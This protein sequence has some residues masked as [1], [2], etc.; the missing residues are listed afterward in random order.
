MGK[1][2]CRPVQIVAADAVIAARWLRS[3]AIKTAYNAPSTILAGNLICEDVARLERLAGELNRKA[4]RRRSGAGF[5]ALIDVGHAAAFARAVGRCRPAWPLNHHPAILR[6]A[7]AMRN[8]GRRKRRG[9]IS[10]DD[11]EMQA[12]VSG[13]FSCEER[14]AKRLAA[15]LRRSATWDR[16]LGEVRARG[17]TIL[18]TDL[19][20]Y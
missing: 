12:R 14:H 2:D 1:R 16:W 9:R 4:L 3:V 8:A 17:Q 5:S 6:L 18:T 20:L 10:L 7:D 11:R 15:R 19:P 13:A